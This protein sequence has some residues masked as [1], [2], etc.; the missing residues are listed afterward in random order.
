MRPFLAGLLA[1]LVG[2]GS[3]PP[4]KA[5]PPAGQFSLTGPASPLELLNGGQAKVAVELNWQRGP[6]EAVELSATAEPAGGGVTAR[7]EPTRLAPAE[8][9]SALVLIGVAETARPGEH[10][11]T[12]TG[13]A[14]K[15][16]QARALV[17]VKVPPKD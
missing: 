17:R 14:D 6:A 10:T 12:V 1:T 9:G 3:P 4:D 16:A 5:G 8:K 2:C 15:A 13:K 7:V 11:V